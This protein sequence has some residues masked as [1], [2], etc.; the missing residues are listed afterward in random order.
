VKESER[1]KEKEEKRDKERERERKE[2]AGKIEKERDLIYVERVKTRKKGK[3]REDW[4]IIIFF[5]FCF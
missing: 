2:K 1:K 5:S 3:E 4:G